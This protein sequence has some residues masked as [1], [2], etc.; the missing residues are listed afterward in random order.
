M[1]KDLG[2][3]L[4]ARIYSHFIGVD[5]DATR[6]KVIAAA[7]QLGPG[8]IRS[9]QRTW[10]PSRSSANAAE[11][12]SDIALELAELRRENPGDD[13]LTWL[14][15]AEYEGT[16]MEDWEIG[17]LLRP[18]RPVPRTTPPATRPRTR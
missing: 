10:S 13:M 5:D 8:T 9:T 4:P 2:K 12:L 14:V 11:T 7:D 1:V 16:K 17:V 3:P 18:A 6:H 15:Q